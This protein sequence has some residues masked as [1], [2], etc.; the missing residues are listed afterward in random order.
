[1]YSDVSLFIDGNKAAGRR[2][3]SVVNRSK[4]MTSGQS[5]ARSG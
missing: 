4:I 3:I 5:A 1:M 2:M